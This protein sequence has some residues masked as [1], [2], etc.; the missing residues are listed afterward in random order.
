MEP[1]A[2]YIISWM[3]KLALTEKS[4]CAG[5]GR[6]SPKWTV[7]STTFTV[8]SNHQ[9]QVKSSSFQGFNTYF[10]ESKVATVRP[11]AGCSQSWKSI[12]WR[13]VY[14]LD[15]VCQLFLSTLLFAK[16]ICQVGM[17]MW[18]LW[19]SSHVSKKHVWTKWW[20]QASQRTQKKTNKEIL[21]PVGFSFLSTIRAP[22]ILFNYSKES[23]KFQERPCVIKGLQSLIL[24]ENRCF[25]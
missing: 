16:K 10:S 8:Q 9:P 23:N 21:L 25:F 19:A 1:L 22:S 2:E 7:R 5:N 6:K 17:I 3:S 14:I 12:I 11:I 15:I 18:Q 13:E 20:D 4:K 24:V